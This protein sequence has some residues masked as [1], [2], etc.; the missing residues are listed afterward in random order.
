MCI[1]KHIYI[2]IICMYIHMYIYIY[3]C[4]YTY[5]YI[6]IIPCQS[7]TSKGIW[8][9]G[10]GSFV[11][12]AFRVDTVPYRHMPLLVHLRPL[13][14]PHPRLLPP[15]RGPRRAG[16]GA[17]SPEPATWKH[18]W[19][20]HGSSIKP[21]TPNEFCQNHAYSNHVFT[22]PAEAHPPEATL[23][24]ALKDPRALPYYHHYCY[25]ITI[26]IIIITNYHCYYYYYWYYE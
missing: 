8:R 9:Q 18:G 1:Y 10:E 13:H 23:R 26:I 20:K 17:A 3:I 11:R 16:G 21:S 4:V 7:C 22:S 19:S 12:S 15:V 24:W 14:A 2:Y 25:Y 6:Y 5:I